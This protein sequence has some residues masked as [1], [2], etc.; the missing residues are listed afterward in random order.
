MPDF[1]PK[2]WP[3]QESVWDYPNPPRVEETSRRL[4]VEFG[5]VTVAETTR[6]L[7]VLERS[8]APIYYFPAEDV[9]T[10]YLRKAATRSFSD[11]AGRAVHWDLRVGD[12]EASNAAWSY[13]RPARPYEALANRVAFFA[14]RSGDCYVDDERVK[15]R[16][17]EMERGWVTKDVAGLS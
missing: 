14:G 15:S 6:A 13:P 5:G 12:H 10:R 11:F 2:S 1:P 16:K 7:R 4:R 8:R 9:D 3:G 17:G